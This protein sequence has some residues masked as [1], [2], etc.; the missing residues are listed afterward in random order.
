[1]KRSA[2][3]SDTTSNSEMKR[4][5]RDEIYYSFIL[6]T[7]GEEYKDRV[8][9]NV[10]P[11]DNWDL[12]S[13]NTMIVSHGNH[14]HVL[15]TSSDSNSKRKLNRILQSL[16]SSH[17]IFLPYSDKFSVFSF[18]ILSK[19]RIH[20]LGAYMRYLVTKYMRLPEDE[21]FVLYDLSVQDTL[22]NDFKEMR[23]AYDPNNDYALDDYDCGNP[24]EIRR[25][26]SRESRKFKEQGQ[27]EKLKNLYEF[28]EDNDITSLEDLDE[29]IGDDIVRLAEMRGKYGSFWR[30]TVE[31]YC[32]TV[33][34]YK[35]QLAK[36]ASEMKTF[37]EAVHSYECP[38]IKL[39]K[40]VSEHDANPIEGSQWLATLFE[41][42]K[43]NPVQFFEDVETIF[44]CK[45]QRV[46]AL[47][48]EGPSTTGKTLLAK[49]LTTPYD[50]GLVGRS[51][52]ATPFYLENLYK[53]HVA[54][55]EEPT[56]TPTTCGDFK[57][58]LGGSDFTIQ[59]KGK[60]SVTL[61]RMPVVITTN[62]PLWTNLRTQGDIEP[63]RKRCITYKLTNRL[64]P[65]KQYKSNICLCTL[66]HF[67]DHL[68]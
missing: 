2:A 61:E 27:I 28:C 6:K 5:K 29:W 63:I 56:I 66:I 48:L 14:V 30:K 24:S 52:D 19:L 12:D 1:M 60:T 64:T 36:K 16:E 68:Q 55:M 47:V 54:L 59:R 21:R 15:F 65:D 3:G 10:A 53:H 58:L 42:N 67:L 32:N 23:D 50:V 57:E 40:M 18:A 31:E 7:D 22:F 20:D 49:L 43:I 25:N 41:A 38:G 35:R 39:H 46:N 13:A 33:V 11:A 4:S 51:G 45:K 37:S 9:F 34:A 44:Q 17:K 8:K 26:V 62:H